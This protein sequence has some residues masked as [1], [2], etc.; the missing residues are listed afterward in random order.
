MITQP[1]GQKPAVAALSSFVGGDG[2]AGATTLAAGAMSA[3]CYFA[4]TINVTGASTPASTFDGIYLFASGAITMQSGTSIRS[5]GTAGVAGTA[6]GSGTANGGTGGTG[7]NIGT[8]SN[9]ATAGAT[10]APTAGTAG[11]GGG[12]S[13]K[14]LA[15]KIKGVSRNKI[16]P[17][18]FYMG[19]S[20]GTLNSDFFSDPAS[21]S[22]I[23][24]RKY[25]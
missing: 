8:A 25:G 18:L 6:G 17:V 4:T 7:G 9:L 13:R 10:S 22:K 12:Y 16:D 23:A 2:S 1:A 11:T 15:K 24:E 21:V 14:V 3:F 19:R 5:D 20:R